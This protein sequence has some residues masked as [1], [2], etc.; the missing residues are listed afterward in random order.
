MRWL[1]LVLM[2]VL[3]MGTMYYIDPDSGN[4]AWN[5]DEPDSAWA[6]FSYALGNT[7]GMAQGDTLTALSGTYDAT[8]T[9][10][11]IN[12]NLGGSAVRASPTVI[13][14][15]T[16]GGAIID[17]GGTAN[18]WMYL[19]GD[20]AY[21]FDGFALQNFAY[22]TIRAPFYGENGA[23]GHTIKNC[24]L[25]TGAAV[26]SVGMLA[27]LNN[28]NDVP[29]NAWTFTGNT[30]WN[31]RY[32]VILMIGADSVTVSGNTFV[33]T[34]SDVANNQVVGVRMLSRQS[35]TPDDDPCEY[36]TIDG[37]TFKQLYKGFDSADND[38]SCVFVTVTNNRIINNWEHG[39]GL[40]EA[41]DCRI[42]GNFVYNSGRGSSGGYGL[43]VQQGYRDTVRNNTIFGTGLGSGMWM[44]QDT[45]DLVI[46]NNV[47]V[48]AGDY[49]FQF[50]APTTGSPASI[51]SMDYNFY[52]D[53]A[54]S[55]T[56]T[57]TTGSEITWAAHQALG[58]DT[59]GSNT[60]NPRLNSAG[61]PFAGSRNA[62]LV[63]DGTLAGWIQRV[64]G[65]GGS[66]RNH[67]RDHDH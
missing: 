23:S 39:G 56:V 2:A 19:A 54:E 44:K 67:D 64:W 57:D 16:P 53:W 38:T 18:R 28:Y 43:Y 30:V 60:V 5:G 1:L 52:Y 66:I 59:N 34:M 12:P 8:G 50:Q 21:E 48:G 13:R 58:R 24:T 32:Q 51:A 11:D 15:A 36:V 31:P 7:S 40:R 41:Y 65:V 49:A 17:G 3:M 35:A 45:F 55:S 14:S 42:E 27:Y 61:A 33:R 26:D 6:T 9:E 22:S 37:N 4:N 47:I 10:D 25:G 29:N 20:D 62:L 46:E 63:A